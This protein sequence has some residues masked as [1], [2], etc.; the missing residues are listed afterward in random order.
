MASEP[1]WPHFRSRPSLL[2][3]GGTSGV[4]QNVP[5]FSTNWHRTLQMSTEEVIGA[6]AG[7]RLLRQMSTRRGERFPISAIPPSRGQEYE[8]TLP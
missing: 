7:T 6:C 1:T 8:S 5:G 3:R 4:D 2:F